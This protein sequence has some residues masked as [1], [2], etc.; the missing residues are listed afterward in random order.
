MSVVINRFSP[1]CHFFLLSSADTTMEM[2]LWTTS[3]SISNPQQ[4]LSDRSITG[5]LTGSFKINTNYDNKC[6]CWYQ[7]WWQ[8]VLVEDEWHFHPAW[9]PC[10]LNIYLIEESIQQ[11]VVGESQQVATMR[12]IFT[13]LIVN[14]KI[15]GLWMTT[16]QML[17]LNSRS[18]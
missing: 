15:D 12:S 17:S 7:S 18:R 8:N 16:P 2:L 10:N 4:P 5:H 3:W 9:R 1:L 13:A 6:G 11:S 14:F